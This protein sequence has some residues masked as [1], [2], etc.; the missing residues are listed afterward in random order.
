MIKIVKD[1][2]NADAVTHGG[3]FHADDVMAT[4]ILAAMNVELKVAR[5]FKA[6]ETFNGIVYDIG[7]G[8]YDHHQKGGN[9]KRGNGVPYASAGLIWKALGSTILSKNEVPDITAGMESIDRLLIETIDGNDNGYSFG[10]VYRTCDISTFIGDMNPTWEEGSFSDDAFVSA[11][12]F[13]KSILMRE[14][15]IEASRQKAGILVNA[16]IK[17]AREGFIILDKYLPW[18]TYLVG[19]SNADNIYY[20]IFPSVR[21]GYNIQAVPPVDNPMEQKKPF[22]LAWR[23]RSGEELEKVTGIKGASF[24]HNAG[25]LCA[26]DNLEAAIQLA[27]LAINLTEL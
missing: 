1:V 10:N 3:I 21:G 16:A 7:G 22:P 26:T 17:D 20:V 2:N 25:F 27:R 18:Q 4:A 11:V 23:G 12:V 9:G 5:V 8:E 13:C 14:I 24:A 15:E 19:N 6:P